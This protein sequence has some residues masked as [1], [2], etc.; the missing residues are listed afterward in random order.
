MDYEV[1]TSETG[2]L[3]NL[4]LDNS[5]RTSSW[6]L[7]TRLS[8]RLDTSAC[9]WLQEYSRRQ[10][11]PVLRDGASKSSGSE[12]KFRPLAWGCLVPAPDKFSKRN[13]VFCLTTAFTAT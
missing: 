10:C 5:P 3:A 13:V 6:G 8:D 2:S 1:G 9:R 4:R 12:F 7:L 11:A